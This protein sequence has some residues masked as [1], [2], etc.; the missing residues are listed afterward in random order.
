MYNRFLRMVPDY[1]ATMAVV[2]T[3]LYLTLFPQPLGDDD[4]PL[5]P[6]ADKVVHAIMF[7]TLAGALIFDR[8]H[9]NRPLDK[10]GAVACAILSAL[11]GG[12]IE[13][14]QGLMDMGR[15]CDILDF[16]ADTVGAFLALPLSRCW[17]RNPT[18]GPRHNKE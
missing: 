17:W 1:Q 11:A 10:R 3:I 14:L 7:G 5:F 6:G 4:F 2:V 12:A 8:W 18:Q 16:I 9:S 13:L 15:G